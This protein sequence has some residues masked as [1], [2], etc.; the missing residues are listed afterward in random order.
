LKPQSCRALE[1]IYVFGFI[2]FIP[3][4]GSWFIRLDPL[5]SAANVFGF[6]EVDQP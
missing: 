4:E 3:V 1:P 2:P 5:L 6:I